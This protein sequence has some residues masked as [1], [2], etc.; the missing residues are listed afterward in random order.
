M[1]CRSPY[2]LTI[3]ARTS[4]P[5][6]RSPWPLIRRWACAQILPGDAPPDPAARALFLACGDVP[7]ADESE[8]N[9]WYDKEHIPLL[10]AVPGVL[11]ARRFL[12]PAGKPRYLTLYELADAHVPRSA[13]WAAAL[14]TPWAKR[15]DTLTRD[16]EWIVATYTAYGARAPLAREGC[17]R[18]GKS[19]RSGRS[20]ACVAA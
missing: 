5:R 4:N 9:K 20:T 15:I 7:E 2:A 17:R 14:D 11:R 1:A 13:P 19:P 12:D 10:A 6:M 3:W 8:F 16:C 18:A